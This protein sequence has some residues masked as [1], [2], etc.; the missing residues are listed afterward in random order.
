MKHI[1]P[2]LIMFIIFLPGCSKLVIPEFE[3]ETVDCEYHRDKD[4]IN[5]KCTAEGIGQPLDLPF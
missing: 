3:A 5:W 2:L 4:N 1:K